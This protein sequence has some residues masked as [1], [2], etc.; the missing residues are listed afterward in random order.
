MKKLTFKT[1][2]KSEMMEITNYI[3][4]EV[5]K[6]GIK[7]GIATIFMPHTTASIMLF[8]KIE[9]NSKRD[10]LKAM[11]E[12]VSDKEAFLHENTTSH[13]KSAL[14]RNSISLIVQ[15]AQIVLG[16]WQGIYLV[17]FDGGREREVL[18]KVING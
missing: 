1:K 9:P 13:I 17:E 10:F 3:K 12:I 2:Y 6:S 14:L 18:V 4:E 11:T 15:D 16:Q 7:N 8:E 5:I